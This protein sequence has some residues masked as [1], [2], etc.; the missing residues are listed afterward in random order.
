MTVNRPRGTRDF[1]PEETARRRYVESVMRKVA[2]SWGYEEI[3]T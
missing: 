3:L 2:L 1:L